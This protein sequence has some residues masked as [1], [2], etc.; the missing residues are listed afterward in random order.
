[1]VF[2]WVGVYNDYMKNLSSWLRGLFIGAVIT[3]VLSLINH[4]VLSISWGNSPLGF[5]NFLICGFKKCG[6]G[7]VIFNWSILPLIF[8]IIWAI[9]GKVKHRK[10]NSLVS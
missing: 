4:Y 8:L 10:Q 9:V 5:A 7:A 2:C 6:T 1:M 3:L